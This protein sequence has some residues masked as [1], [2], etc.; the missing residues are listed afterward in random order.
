MQ[1]YGDVDLNDVKW[2]ILRQYNRYHT[3]SISVVY[4]T[5]SFNFWTKK[6]IQLTIEQDSYVLNPI[7]TSRKGETFAERW[8][9]V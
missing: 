4:E 6:H 5:E 2:P 8:D 3:L 1:S 7:E 9:R